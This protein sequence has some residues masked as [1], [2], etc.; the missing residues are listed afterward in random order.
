MAVSW[1]QKQGD[2]CME[3][4]LRTAVN[5]VYQT[6]QAALRMLVTAKNEDAIRYSSMMGIEND[7]NSAWEKEHQDENIFTE[8]EARDLMKAN[9]LGVEA[10]YEG[11]TR[12]LKETDSKNM[13]DIAC[14]Y[15][16]RALTCQKAGI[17]YVGLDVPIVVEKLNEVAGKLFDQTAH[18]VYVSGDATNAASL[19]GAA[20]LMQ[21]KL[22]ISSEGLLQYLNRSE[23]EQLMA[24]VRTVLLRHGGA[25]FTSDMDVQYN[26][27]AVIS[28][29]S[30]DAMARYRKSWQKIGEARGYMFNN[31]HLKST[32]DKIAIFEAN[33]LHVE[34]VPFYTED[35]VL[36]MLCAMSPEKQQKEKEAMS[37][38][39]FWKITAKT[40]VT[41]TP[42]SVAVERENLVV[43]SKV[44]AGKLCLGLTGRVDTL[45]AP[46]VLRVFEEAAAG[47]ALSGVVVDGFGLEYISSAGLR[48]LMIMVKRLGSVCI[49]GAS[50][51]IKE[52]FETTG[53]NDV[54][55][56][57]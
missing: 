40:D 25:W 17:D 23:L 13:L 48:V 11:I 21:G 46:D 7:I 19:A 44:E 45:S 54:I 4:D 1:V 41:Q 26:Q 49:N 57:K 9:A 15:T 37:G 35:T 14:G 10:R 43:T 29:G 18:P 39:R 51:S 8:Q 55:D 42:S 38:F 53:F 31:T 47:Q 27:L 33:G 24:A 5:P 32:E 34:Q 28:V 20:D 16:P 2:I 36:E 56:V 30:P 52:I 22:F 12:L 3:K 6:A 50:D